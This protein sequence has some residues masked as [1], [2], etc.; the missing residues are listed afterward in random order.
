MK[1][2]SQGVMICW[3]FPPSK[4][5][6]Y[7]LNADIQEAPF[8][9]AEP[10]NKRAR[11]GEPTGQFRPELVP[12]DYTDFT[13]LLAGAYA[14]MQTS[15]T[16]TSPGIADIPFHQFNRRDGVNDA[17][18]FSGDQEEAAGHKYGRIVGGM[19]MLEVLMHY[20]LIQLGPE[21]DKFD[22]AARGATKEEQK[23]A[24]NALKK[25]P[26]RDARVANIAKVADLASAIG[27]WDTDVTKQGIIY[28]IFAN[29]NFNDLYEDD[30][31]EQAKDD[32]HRFCGDSE[33]ARRIVHQANLRNDHTENYQ[34]ARLL[35]SKYT[36]G[37]LV[38]NWFSKLSQIIGRSMNA[39]APGDTLHALAGH[40]N[41]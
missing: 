25:N 33:A 27:L 15:K 35:S 3:R 8:N 5:S 37:A 6:T 10:V 12:F 14:N 24:F 28:D 19:S 9:A 20:G 4:M 38:G 36:E 18:C 41:L 11:M 39:C 16:D 21:Y 30:R 22:A 23:I 29:M 34:K 7:A 31:V 1:K 26:N 40:F 13:S 17:Y 32:F 2:N